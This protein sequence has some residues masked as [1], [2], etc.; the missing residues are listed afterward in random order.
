[1][2]II[3]D[4][5]IPFVKQAFASIGEV[6]TL[7]GRLICQADLQDAE[8][9]LVRSITSVNADLLK[10]TSIKFV[11]SATSG[12]NHIDEKYLQQNNISFAHALG[13]NAIS[14]AQYIMAGICYWS[15]QKQKP[16]SQLSIGIIGYGNVGAQVEKLCNQFGIT[17][18]LND[19]PLSDG[20]QKGLKDIKTALACDIVS[21]H[22]PFTLKGKYATKHLVNAKNI[23]Q[24]KAGGLFLNA[25]R[26]EVVDEQALL[27]RKLKNPDFSIIL[28]VWENEPNINAEILTQ[29]LIATPHIAGYSI[30]GKIKGTEMIYQA[31]CAFLNFTPEW[32]A[33]NVDLGNNL[34][35]DIKQAKHQDVRISV[36]DAY[37][38]LEDS[39]LLKKML[40]N[41]ALFNGKYF[42]GLRK[43]YAARREWR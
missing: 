33:N 22:V 2:K 12:I 29:V 16:L 3:A 41:T 31:C 11:A 1:M 21:L 9:L 8:I 10:D 40:I 20:G 17:S 34:A 23:T 26:G 27:S 30:D 14:V 42:D 6:F 19:P 13:S 38:I 32:S 35:H 39:I 5:N 25:S 18:I 43:N 4:E 28:D 7:P 15:I 24:L 36:L 37:N